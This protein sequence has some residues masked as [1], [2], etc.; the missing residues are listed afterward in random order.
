MSARFTAYPSIRLLFSLAPLA[1]GPLATAQE[2]PSPDELLDRA[3]EAM[4]GNAI[5]KI[6]SYAASAEM[7]APMGTM[8][9]QVTWAKPHWVLIKQSVPQMGEMEMG[10]DGKVGWMNNP[11][12]GY[13]LMEGDQLEGIRQQ[14]FHARTMHLRPTLKE[15][16]TQVGDVLRKEFDGVACY[17]LQLV[18][19][20]DGKTERGAAYFGVESGLILGMRTID[21]TPQ[22]AV[23]TTV[24]FKE[25]KEIAGVNFF[26]R[27]D[28]SGGPMNITVNYTRIQL[29]AVKPEQLV[30]PDEVV[31]L[32]KKQGDEK[33]ASAMRLEDF[34]PQVQRMIR[35]ML[36]GL[37][38]DDVNALR[39]TRAM[40]SG[41]AERMPG[42][43][44]KGMEYVVAK[45]DER[46]KELEGDDP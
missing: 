14:A 19:K 2:L 6:E 33:D 36:D 13:Q 4:G 40:L 31:E 20:A 43:F 3:Y 38:M 45:I 5:E 15:T 11:I 24:S 35:G 23:V 1:L 17:E 21:D 8:T 27:M 18:R 12:M 28:V 30:I 7:T 34:S 25:W 39:T 32:A 16:N 44:K 9:S 42:E 41:Q 26:H 10:T 37:S 29:N 22:G 46:L